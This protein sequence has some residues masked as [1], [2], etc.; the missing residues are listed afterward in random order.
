MLYNDARKVMEKLF[1]ILNALDPF[2]EL[3]Q[4]L[5]RSRKITESFSRGIS[6]RHNCGYSLVDFDDTESEL[7]DN[8]IKYTP[9]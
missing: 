1:S 5:D 6:S 3:S 7:F 2:K 9:F 4:N 8:D